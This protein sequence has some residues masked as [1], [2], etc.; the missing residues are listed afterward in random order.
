M[1]STLITLDHASPLGCGTLRRN[2]TLPNGMLRPA[3]IIGVGAPVGLVP[4]M[5]TR[6]LLLAPIV[7]GG[8]VPKASCGFVVRRAAFKLRAVTFI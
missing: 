6:A 8:K 1:V 2:C 5:A 3:G 4:K 7:S